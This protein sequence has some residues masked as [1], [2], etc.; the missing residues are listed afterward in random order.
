MTSQRAQQGG[1][2]AVFTSMALWVV[3]LGYFVDIFD[4]T[5][6]GMV[7]KQSLIDLGVAADQ[8]MPVG[9]QLLSAQMLGM[10]A[11][12]VLFGVLGDLK[13]RTQMLYL[14][15]LCYS[16]GNILNGF[17]QDIP[18]YALLRFFTGIGLAGELGL[19]ITLLAEVLPRGNRGVGTALVATVGVLGATAAELAVHYLSWRH[20]YFL[21]GA[22]GLMLL[23]L[24]VNLRDSQLFHEVKVAQPYF[25]Q[26]KGL[27]TR[28]SSIKK[29]LLC[30]LVGVPIWFIAGVVMT[31]SPELAKELG[32]QG[33]VSAAKSIAVSYQGLALGDLASGWF[34]QYLRSRKWAI[35]P[36]QLF[37]ILSLTL[38]YT[39]S[40]GR[41]SSFYYV[42]CFF[43]GLG[44][45]FWALFVTIAAEQFGTRIRATAATLIPNLVRASVY[46]MGFSV[47]WL[48]QQKE[49]SFAGA[50]ILVG[51][52]VFS[53]ALWANLQLKESFD[54]D[55]EFQ[56][57]E[58][59]QG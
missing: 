5:L 35:L 2:L 58:L 40:S 11:G 12:G 48:M 38:L 42:L 10:L 22:L 27:F 7:R 54:R 8:L 44:A 47:T 20:C 37:T 13:G 9:Q 21:G 17:V 30:S 26:L 19:G 32:V 25:Q 29:I 57:G 45:G 15:I 53:L 59:E 43:I 52:V 24:R 14:S 50:S 1:Y 56:E 4:I 55:L 34:S 3:T 39:L 51:I 41:S 46:P 16:V 28:W 23:L 18:S 36:F 31:F 6:F 49:L 33:E